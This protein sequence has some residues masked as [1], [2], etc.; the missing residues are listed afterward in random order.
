MVLHQNT[1]VNT[2]E[3]LGDLSMLR[4][5]WTSMPKETYSSSKARLLVLTL[6]VPE[7]KL[8]GWLGERNVYRVSE[9]NW[10]PALGP[11]TPHVTSFAGWKSLW[12][13]NAESIR[14]DPT[15][16][17]PAAWRI[18]PGTP[19]HKA[20]SSGQDLAGDASR[21]ARAP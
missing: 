17:D 5:E 14:L 15:I 20:G 18:M 8:A 4:N 11:Q 9:Q 13:S 2:G 19:G 10:C 7:L 1:I 6:D 21:I 3:L 12:K 16:Y